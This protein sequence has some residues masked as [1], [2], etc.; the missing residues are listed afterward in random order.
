VGGIVSNRKEDKNFIDLSDFIDKISMDV[1]KDYINVHFLTPYQLKIKGAIILEELPLF[2]N[3]YDSRSPNWPQRVDE[4]LY[5]F[6]LLKEKFI[7][8][9]GFGVYDQLA[10]VA[11]NNRVWQAIFR[12]SKEQRKGMKIEI[13]L[14]LRYP[15][16]FP[17]TRSGAGEAHVTMGDKCFGE[18]TRRWRSDGKFGIAHFL[19]ILSYYYA[20]EHRAVGIE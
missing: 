19:V 4:E 7:Q 14:G 2:E 10:Q 20:L 6:D 5:M 9:V 12:L 13:R 11:E 8:Q 17:R 18:L 3:V 15:Y 16:E 1:Y